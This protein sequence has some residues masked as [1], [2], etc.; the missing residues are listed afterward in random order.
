LGYVPEW[1]PGEQ[2][3]DAALVQ[4]FARYLQTILQR[5]NQAPEQKKLAFLDLLGLGLVPEQAAGAP[6]V[7]AP[8]RENE[9][10][11]KEALKNLKGR[12]PVPDEERLLQN[13]DSFS[14]AGTQVAAQPPPGK[15]NPIVFETERD[16]G[17]ASARLLNVV[18]LLPAA[19]QY[20]DHSQAF[21]A[22]K[23]MQLFKPL[24]LQLTPHA[25]YLAHDPLLALAG[26]TILTVEFEL[27]GAT[28][29]K[30]D[31]SWAYWNG[32]RWSELLLE[33]DST[34]GLRQS[35]SIKL[36]AGRT[37]AIETKVNGIAAFW[38]CGELSGPLLPGQSKNL[39][40][41]E[42]VQ[43]STMMA[44]PLLEPGVEIAGFHPDK[45]HLRIEGAVR[46]EAGEPF[47]NKVPVKI[48]ISTIRSSNAHRNRNKAEGT[49]STSSTGGWAKPGTKVD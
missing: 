47:G 7:F 6:L 44:Q 38:I 17:I 36:T 10:A 48:T 49:F 42:K 45:F 3:A 23:P 12:V 22:G 30:W 26:Q 15:T 43:L 20:A 41:V 40:Q 1:Q 21:Q 13:F 18:S 35:G 8:A 11:I 28:S 4:I 14:P 25:I 29:K 46:D 34:L 37:E 9:D 5:L 32:S 27:T 19:D 33:N 31:I 16:V 2:G 24:E 39:P